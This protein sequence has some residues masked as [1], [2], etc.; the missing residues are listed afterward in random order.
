MELWFTMENYGTPEKLWYYEQN[1]GTIPRTRNFDL[2]RKKN[3][4]D[5]QKLKD[6]DL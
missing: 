3:I 1:Y 4:V 2:R 5:Y 6:F